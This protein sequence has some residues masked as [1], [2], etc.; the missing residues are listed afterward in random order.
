MAKKTKSQKLN[1]DALINS[2]D[3]GEEMAN[4]TPNVSMKLQA[5]AGSGKTHFALTFFSHMAKDLKPEESLMCIID[6]D[7]EGQSALVRR[8][9]IVPVELR[10]RIL[11]KVCQTPEDVNQI[12]MAYIDLLKKHSE[13]FPNGNRLILLEN[14]AAFYIGCRDFYSLEVH[15]VSEADLMLARQSQAI[16]EG[17]KTLPAFAEGQMHS[18][19]VINKLF[20]TPFQRLKIASEM[21]HCHFMATVLLREYTENYGQASAK[22]VI[23]AAGRADMTD[24]IF[25]W[26]L[27]LSK[28]QRTSPKG[29]FQTKHIA[30]VR[31]SRSCKPFQIQNPTQ[32]KFWKAVDAN[33][34][35]GS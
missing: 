28:K 5:F 26:I 27:E 25:D 29:E 8:E 19:K 11:R 33:R 24:P 1:Y 12:S 21:F 2:C 16:S 15:G 34:L 3:T 22:K 14:E 9:E 17:K 20:F 13:E 6:C 35:N 10:S 31:K 7:L 32:E 23:T 30:V 4:R 18:Y